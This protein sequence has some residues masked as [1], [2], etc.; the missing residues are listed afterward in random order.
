MATRGQLV[1]LV[2]QE[3]VQRRIEQA[4]GDRQASHDLEHRLEIGPLHGQDLGQRPASARLGVG[5]DHL[6]HGEDAVLVEEHVLGAAQPDAFGAERAGLAGIVG[7]VGIGPHTQAP[8]L[9]GPAH[10]AAEIAGEFRLAHLDA[11]FQDFARGAVD[12][13]D[14]SLA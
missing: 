2:R 10:D 11:S 12:G 5:A 9:V 8:H 3:L 1:L 13:D 7:G 14:V 6:A 4:D